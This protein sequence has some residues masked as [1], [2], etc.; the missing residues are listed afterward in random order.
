[1]TTDEKIEAI[2]WGVEYLLEME[3]INISDENSVR[4]RAK[5]N[6]NNFSWCDYSYFDRQN[7]IAH[8]V[9]F[10]YILLRNKNA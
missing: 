4:L 3:V 1:M 10:H 8:I 2:R 7:I 6:P 9:Q 5:N